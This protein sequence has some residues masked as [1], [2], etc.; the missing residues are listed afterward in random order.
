MGCAGS[1]PKE[2]DPADRLRYATPAAFY[3]A[4]RPMNGAGK[5]PMRLLLGSWI[6]TRA[7]EIRK[8]KERSDTAALRRLA[9]TYRQEM[10]EEAFMAVEEVE[11]LSK[12]IPRVWRRLAAGGMSYCWETKDHPDPEC[13]SFLALADALERCYEEKRKGEYAYGCFPEDIGIFWDYP[14]LFQHPPGGKRT[15]EQDQCFKVLPHGARMQ[16]LC[17]CVL[18]CIVPSVP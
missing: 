15:E 12:T 3:A 10:P 5:P 8:A 11:E 14:C 2:A 17:C 1:R 18:C 16:C 7:K 9:I 13:N 6:R 4:L